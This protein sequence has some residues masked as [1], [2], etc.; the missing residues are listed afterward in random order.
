MKIVPIVN[1]KGGVGKTTV[2]RHLM[3]ML[4][5]QGSRVLA[6]DMDAQR[7]LD[8]YL[9]VDL[10][11]NDKTSINMYHV[12]RNEASIHEAIIHTEDG[13]IAR[14]DN[15]M[16]GF[17]GNPLITVNE[18]LSLKD[19]PDALY[20]HVI[21]N[22]SF[23]LNPNTHDRTIL[24]RALNDVKNDYDF[25]LI[26]TNPDLGFLTTLSLL[27]GS[28]VYPLIPAFAERSSLHSIM[29]LNDTLSTI[30]AN[31]FSTTIKVVGILISKFERTSNENLM[32]EQISEYA[33]EMETTLFHSKIPKS[34]IVAE[35]MTMSTSAFER[36]KDS[37]VE[38]AYREFCKEF[39][40]RMSV[41][42]DI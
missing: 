26:D 18:A 41:L 11:W 35:G 34:V 4:T 14:A 22:L 38:I 42:S 32:L 9:G 37:R 33:D 30:E 16:Y 21:D 5:E 23:P 13:D 39:L 29:A 17:M 36:Q 19:T 12:L 3:K 25:V 24:M 1:Q 2:C 8:I 7:N 10:P 15:R 40:S 27:S 28:L 20:K 6:I 31:D